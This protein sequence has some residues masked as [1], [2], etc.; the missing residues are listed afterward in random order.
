MTSHFAARSLVIPNPLEALETALE[1]ASAEDVI[2]ATGSLYLVG[3]LRAYWNR[4][5]N[6]PTARVNPAIS[7]NPSS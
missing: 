5:G 3:D 1:M 7:V 2:F 6:D 4:R